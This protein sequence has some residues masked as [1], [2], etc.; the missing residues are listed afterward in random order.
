[1]T[2]GAALLPGWIALVLGLLMLGVTAAAARYA[3]WRALWRVPLRQHLLFGCTCLIV[4]LWL[5]SVKAIEGLWL[6]LLGITT[7]TLVLGWR[8]AMLAGAAAIVLHTLLIGEPLRAVGPAWLLTVFLPAS[9]SRWLVHALRRVRSRNL[10]IYMLG[11]GFGGGLLSVLVVGLAAPPLLWLIGRGDWAAVALANWP[12]L[13]LFL[14]PEGF[15]N[16]TMV[17]GLTVFYPQVMK[18]FDESHYLDE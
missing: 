17:T 12:M 3:D 9:S 13:T 14:F 15:I 5:M 1:M 8:F 11:A 7:L 4:I 18:T 16:G 6:H 10:Y 2:I